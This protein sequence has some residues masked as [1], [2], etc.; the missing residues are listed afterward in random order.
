MESANFQAANI[1]NA[2]SQENSEFAHQQRQPSAKKNKRILLQ[3]NGNNVHKK[4]RK[5]T[6]RL[7]DVDE[8]QYEFSVLSMRLRFG[9]RHFRSARAQNRKLVLVVVLV[10]RSKGPFR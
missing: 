5:G 6:L 8:Y 2:S 7:E 4:C 3:T 10:H 1:E 9:D